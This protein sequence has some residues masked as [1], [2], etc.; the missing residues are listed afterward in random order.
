[1]ARRLRYSQHAL[2]RLEQRHIRRQWVEA[3]VGTRPVSRGAERIH[4][5]SATELAARFGAEF[6]KGLRVV[7]DACCRRVVTVHWLDQAVS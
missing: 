2:A 1:M 5:L 3:V 6:R 4:T 7:V